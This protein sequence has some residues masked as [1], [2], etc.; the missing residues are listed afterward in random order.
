M[1]AAEREHLRP[2]HPRGHDGQT[3]RVVMRI[4]PNEGSRG[5]DLIQF[6]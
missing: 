5:Q 4:T 2:V 1:H 6:C 3:V